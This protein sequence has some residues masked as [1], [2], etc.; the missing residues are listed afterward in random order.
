MEPFR[1]RAE[2]VSLAVEKERSES[3]HKRQGQKDEGRQQ[4]EHQPLLED[5]SLVWLVRFDL[6]PSFSRASRMRRYG[7]TIW[8]SLLLTKL[9]P[10]P[11]KQ[12]ANFVEDQDRRREQKN[13]MDTQFSG[14]SSSSLCVP[15]VL[16]ED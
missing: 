13:F 4:A 1:V 6:L 7:H 3:F 10:T 2:V 15:V 8:P 14:T 5:G 12:G 11:V 9:L 16:K